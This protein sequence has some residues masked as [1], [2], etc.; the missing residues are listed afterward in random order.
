MAPS[1]N[2]DSQIKDMADETDDFKGLHF[3]E[4]RKL[5]HII[6]FI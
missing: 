5:K 2:N 4:N 6:T 1:Q 3:G